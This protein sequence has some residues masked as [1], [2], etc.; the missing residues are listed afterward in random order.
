MSRTGWMKIMVWLPL[1]AVAGGASA[2]VTATAKAFVA[3]GKI[4]AAIQ[5]ERTVF[6]EQLN[7]QFLL[8]TLAKKNRTLKLPQE[9][10]FLYQEI[11]PVPLLSHKVFTP[12]LNHFKQSIVFV[13]GRLDRKRLNIV[14]WSVSL[15]DPGGE[16]V[17]TFSGAGHPPTA[18]YW[19]G[20]DRENLPVEVGR[21]YIPEITLEDYY[22]A[23]VSLPQKKLDLNQFIW[24]APKYLK[25]GATQNQV[26][27][28]RRAR[29]SRQGKRIMREL[30][31]LVSQHDAVLLDIECAG[32]D[33][34]LTAERARALQAYFAKENMRLKKIR[35]KK[36]AQSSQAVFYIMAYRMR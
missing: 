21:G 27:T 1:L 4:R 31:Q 11:D 20:R 17:K 12:W 14:R 26:F 25:A 34:D 35:I 2:Q 5:V 29:F 10:R 24:Q 7:V 16:V 30:S 13:V 8:D 33:L 22:G 28:K 15:H 32:P 6:A 19:N 9:P 3:A 18:F 36:V 23:R